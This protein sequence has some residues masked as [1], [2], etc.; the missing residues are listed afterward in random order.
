MVLYPLWIQRICL[1]LLEAGGALIAVEGE[2]VAASYFERGESARQ[3]H[4]CPCP[5]LSL[6]PGDGWKT[7]TL[8]LGW[9][10]YFLLVK[11]RELEKLCF[12]T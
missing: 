4:I 7:P 12:P 11:P 2:L 5:V 10:H 6:L 3:P 1:P 8:N 9:P